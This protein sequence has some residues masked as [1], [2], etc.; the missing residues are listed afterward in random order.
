MRVCLGCLNCRTLD[1][2]NWL[3]DPKSLMHLGRSD[4]LSDFGAPEFNVSVTAMD[5]HGDPDASAIVPAD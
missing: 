4:G 3:M 2:F 5:H 1:E